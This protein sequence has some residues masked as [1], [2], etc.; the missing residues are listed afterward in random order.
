[1]AWVAGLGLAVAREDLLRLLRHGRSRCRDLRLRLLHLGV[2]L[3]NCFG[4]QLIPL[5]LDLVAIRDLSLE[6]PHVPR[7]ARRASNALEQ[8]Y[9]Q[10]DTF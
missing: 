4:Q 7:K 2:G 6:V 5:V 9:T 1:M 3:R 8:M 10:Q